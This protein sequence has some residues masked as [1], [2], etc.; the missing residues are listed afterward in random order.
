[1]AEDRVVVGTTGP[2]TGVYLELE[3]QVVDPVP[4]RPMAVTTR[5][6]TRRYD[7]RQLLEAGDHGIVLSA[8]RLACPQGQLAYLSLEP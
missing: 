2:L 6:Q 8:V 1:M 3:V 4:D 5:R 7:L